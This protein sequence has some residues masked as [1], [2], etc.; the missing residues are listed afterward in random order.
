MGKLL[1]LFFKL[2]DALNDIVEYD[3]EHD[4]L[5]NL[6]DETLELLAN[7]FNKDLQEVRSILYDFIDALHLIVNK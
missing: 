6:D 1:Q 2:D 5:N 3:L 4:I 7:V